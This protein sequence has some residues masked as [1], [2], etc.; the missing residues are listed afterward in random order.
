MLGELEDHP[1]V[2]VICTYL[3]QF[4]QLVHFKPVSPVSPVSNF[5]PVRVSLA[6]LASSSGNWT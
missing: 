3:R 2:S 4:E 1:N 6:C 5:K